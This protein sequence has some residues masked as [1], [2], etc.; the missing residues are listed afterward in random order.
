MGINAASAQRLGE[1]RGAI[2]VAFAAASVPVRE[3]APARVKRALA[4]RG[5]A[6]KAAIQRLVTHLLRLPRTPSPDAADALALALCGM[7]VGM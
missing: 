5:D 4:G 2:L 7:R 6:S 1:A 3:L